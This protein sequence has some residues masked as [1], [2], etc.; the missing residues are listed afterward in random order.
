M[1]PR[2]PRG[3][4]VPQRTS[5]LRAQ[6]AAKNAESTFDPGL[7]P[8][9]TT[10]YPAQGAEI[11]SIA[12]RSEDGRVVN[13]LQSGQTYYLEMQG[14]FTRDFAGVFFGSRYPQHPGERRVQ[15]QRYPEE[16]S[17]VPD[18]R[19]GTQFKV[20]FAFNMNLIQ[21]RISLVAACGRRRS[22]HAHIE[23]WMP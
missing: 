2:V 15:D 22:R 1:V 13:V 11:Q 4:A 12:F 6:D 17:Y 16:G 5:C 9:T 23:L 19:A 18:A 7:V 14:V 8:E 10:V 20:R 21:A 3:A